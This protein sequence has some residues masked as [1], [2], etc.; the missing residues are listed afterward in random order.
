[1]EKIIGIDLGTTN[2][3]V[4]I[5][6]NGTA[7]I[8]ENENGLKLIP[9]VVGIS[10]EGKLLVG[11]EALR[12]YAASPDSTVKSVKRR[13]G[14]DHQ[15][16]LN[17]QRFSATEISSIILKTLKA[18]AEAAVGETL[19]KAVIT[20]PAY[21]SDAQRQ[22]TKQ[23]GEL[24]GLEVVRILNEPTAAAM[25]YNLQSEVPEK[26]LV[27]DLGGGTFDVSIVEISDDVTEVLASHG[28]NMLGG[29]DF[30][31]KLQ[32]LLVQEFE[33]QNGV[34]LRNDP[35]A[36]NR[37]ERVA[38]QTKI[39]LSSYV[40][41][42]VREEF[43]SKKGTEPLHLS[44][45][46]S[47]ENF[48]MLIESQLESTLHSIDR[49]LEDAHLKPDEIDRVVLAGGSTRIPMVRKLLE[50]HLGK[51]IYDEIDPDLCV[52]LG[53]AYQA[54][55]LAGEDI[56]SIL[57][58]VT[59]YS[60]GVKALVYDHTNFIPDYFSVIIPRNTVIP[61]S[62]S[63]VYSNPSDN[64][65]RILVDVYQ[66]EQPT[67]DGNIQLGEIWIRDLPPAP[68]D[69]LQIE[70]HFDFDVNGILQVSAHDRTSGKKETLTISST[71]TKLSPP[72]MVKVQDR[73]EELWETRSPQ[74]EK[75]NQEYQF[76][77]EHQNLYD[78]AQKLLTS[79]EDE[80]ESED[81]QQLMTDLEAA[82]RLKNMEKMGQVVEELSDVVYYL[83][84]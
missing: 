65:D 41:V 78:R 35:R 71:N 52:A 72:Q 38:E 83:E 55:I 74:S 46:I 5:V 75:E 1:M 82:Y 28:N 48:E 68:A 8:L 51:T 24:A 76:S 36:M 80:N 23:A 20:V 29:D 49:A 58:D 79:I 22:A 47:R 4:A 59:P 54:G 33:S 18:Q 42:D 53:A 30:D 21:F 57:V 70:V 63:E 10:P 67:T 17:D 60:L 19:S 43:L 9:S 25:V 73:I 84:Q 50:Q 44:T 77:P 2:S 81:L 3:S 32:N 16:Q 15:F 56:A 7:V 26:V 12:Q 11:D 27:Y 66:G 34:D 64:M 14:T 31:R 39:K 13:M 61:V 6:Q 69:S 45:T 62:R 40:F 37:L